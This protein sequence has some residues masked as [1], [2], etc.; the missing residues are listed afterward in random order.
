MKK[1]I[2]MLLFGLAVS[3]GSWVAPLLTGEPAPNTADILKQEISK[4]QAQSADSPLGESKPDPAAA[5][6][7]GALEGAEHPKSRPVNWGIVLGLAVMSGG[8][9]LSIRAMGIKAA[10]S[11]APATE[12]IQPPQMEW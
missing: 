11:F 10:E 9:V 12:P 5:K 1:N 2:T 6:L 8:I 4:T 3:I 7:L